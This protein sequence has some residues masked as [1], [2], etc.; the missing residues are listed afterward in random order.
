[1]KNKLLGIA[2]LLFMIVSLTGCGKTETPKQDEKET[3][4]LNDNL[5]FEI[6]SELSLLSLVSEDNKV[7]IVS[8]DEIVD[9]S[10]LG[11]KEITIKYLVNGKE[12]EKTF[13]ITIT[14]TQAPT[15]KFTK[16]LSTTSGTKIN[17]LK[18]VKVSDNSNEEI[19]ATI[20]GDYDFN[21]E[22]TYKLKYVAVDSSGNKTEEEFTLKVNKKT[23]TSSSNSSTSN[24][25]TSSSNNSSNSN[26]NNSNE[27]TKEQIIRNLY[28]Y[29]RHE[30]GIW[31]SPPLVE[32]VETSNKSCV[33]NVNILQTK[34]GMDYTTFIETYDHTDTKYQ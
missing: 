15:I 27:V 10:I 30:D 32:S 11:D 16:E 21:K 18:G 22:G 17:L 24:N 3:I 13:T 2:L 1:M 34:F 5:E 26:N 4:I 29:C 7:E 25:N 19:N 6:N 23:T 33:E 8:D 31:F 14:D 20:E 9:T 12:E 28:K